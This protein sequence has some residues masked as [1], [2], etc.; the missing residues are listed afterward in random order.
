MRP[1]FKIHSR[2][3][4]CRVFTRSAGGEGDVASHLIASPEN[5]FLL[6]FLLSDVLSI[7][8]NAISSHTAGIHLIQGKI[9]IQ[10]LLQTIIYHGLN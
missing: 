1:I 8:F 9:F 3:A 2:V 4:L 10:L 7:T 5:Q 6:F